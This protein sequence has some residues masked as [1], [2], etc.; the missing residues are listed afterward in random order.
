MGVHQMYFLIKGNL[1]KYGYPEV[2]RLLV[3]VMYRNEGL[4]V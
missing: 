1:M 3:T 2:E 4:T